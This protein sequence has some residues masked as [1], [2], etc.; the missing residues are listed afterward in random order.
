M[1]VGILGGGLSGLSL[2]YFLQN[3]KEVESIDIIE[4]DNT[5]GGLC[6]SYPIRDG[7]FD[8]GPHIL[9]SKNPQILEIIV[10]LLDSNVEKKKRNN[11]VC[12]NQKLSGYPIE[13]YLGE[14][15]RNI[16]NYCLTTFLRNP[17]ELNVPTNLL[18]A[19]LTTFGEGMTK[20]YFQP[21]NEKIWKYDPAFI[22][23]KMMG[24]IPNPPV[25]DILRGA[26]GDYTEGFVHQLYFY[27]PKQ[28]G[29]ASLI[30][31][32]ISKLSDKVSGYGAYNIATIIPSNKQWFV[33]STTGKIE[34]YDVLI[35]TIPLVDL[36]H[37]MRTPIPKEVKHAVSRLRSNSHLSLAFAVMEDTLGDSLAITIPDKTTDIHRVTKLNTLTQWETNTLLAEI[38][39]TQGTT[40][41]YMEDQQ[42][43]NLASTQLIDLGFVP[44]IHSFLE[45][46]LLRTPY[47]YVIYDLEHTK[48]ME[49][50]RDFYEKKLGLFLR[51]RFGEHEYLNMDTVFERSQETAKQI[52]GEI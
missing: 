33:T 52:V 5:F 51:G 16:A 8:I 24:R 41:D 25:E 1:K 19:F 4:K 40:F 14:L 10:D 21:Y 35:S 44:S 26:G 36:T 20:F 3:Y 23:I 49:I 7:Y 17:Y 12:I 15:D 50:I 48:N 18:Q 9:F 43:L 45:G 22:D 39:Y 31:A 42:I 38:T 46:H 13:N 30:N 37:V 6:R 47:A 32:L 27:Y 11:K 28:G 29:I 2:A 34:V